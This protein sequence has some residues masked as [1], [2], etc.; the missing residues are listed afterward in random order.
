MRLIATVVATTTAAL[1]GTAIAIAAEK[2]VMMLSYSEYIDPEIPKAYLAATGVTVQIDVYESQDDML[3]KLQAGGVSQYDIVVA[4]DVVVPTM[5]KLGLVQKLDKT[6][7]PH[8]VNIMEKFKNPA[9]DPGNTYSYPYQWGTAGLMYATAKVKGEVSW[10]LLF[11]E[12]KQPGPFVMMDEMRTMTGIAAMFLG[13]NASTR[14]PDEIKAA[15]ALLAKAKASP[16]CLGFDGGVGGM[17]K[18][19]AG[20][21]VAAVVYNGDA[22]RNIMDDKFA[23]T[24]PKEG[25]ILWVDNLL[26]CAK[27]PNAKGG[28][29]FINHLLD[30]KVG[31]QLSNFNRY[32]T[33][34]QASLPLITDADRTNPAI[35]PDEAQMKTCQFQEDVGAETRIYDQV[36]TAVK[37]R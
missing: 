10:A 37:A 1:L 6:A 36:W 24:V 5:I 15:G 12:A 31:A 17:N 14:K 29:A 8:G 4:T 9:F 19:L 33:P 7:I 35:Y 23:Y 18:V 34:N 22:V 11:D 27:A 32:A 21:A 13:Y 3:A 20:E 25:G 26:I 16:K 2:P 28:H 30:A